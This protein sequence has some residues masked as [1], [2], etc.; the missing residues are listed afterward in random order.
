MM[1]LAR[2]ICV[3]LLT[4]AA[5]IGYAGQASAASPQPADNERFEVSSIKA[6]RPIL[7]KTIAA[8]KKGDAV[9]AKA[10]A[11]LGTPDYRLAG[12]Q[13]ALERSNR[14]LVDGGV[15]SSGDQRNGVAG[16]EQHE[17]GHHADPYGSPGRARLGMP[18]V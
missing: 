4:I 7:V 2:F 13:V 5:S 1:R 14:G 10:E 9:E 11:Q 3:G 12:L 18:F 16:F 8:L 15:L 17:T 6:V